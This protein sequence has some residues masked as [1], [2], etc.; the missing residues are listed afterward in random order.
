MSTLFTFHSL[1]AA[2]QIRSR[3]TL[4]F[5]LQGPARPPGMCVAFL[6]SPV[7]S[8][9]IQPSCSQEDMVDAFRRSFISLLFSAEAV[10]FKYYVH[11]RTW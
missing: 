7:L 8:G 4:C 3:W 5:F 1:H 10:S 6:P 2:N 11:V 9:V